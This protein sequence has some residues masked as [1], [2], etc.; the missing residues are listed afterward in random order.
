MIR[1][2]FQK[3]YW[4]WYEERRAWTEQHQLLRTDIK[5]NLGENVQG[6]IKDWIWRARDRERSFMKT[7][8]T[9]SKNRLEE[10]R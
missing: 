3:D 2:V 8:S 5:R 9:R 4:K 6:L 10:E 1:S 7:N